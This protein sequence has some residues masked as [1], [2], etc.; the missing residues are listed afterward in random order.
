M[1]KT[2]C[3]WCRSAPRG[4]R[5]RFCSR[6][7]RQRAWR[8]RCRMESFEASSQ[9]GRFA[10]ADPPYPGLSSKYYSDQPSFGGEVDHVALIASLEASG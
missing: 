9:P 1:G 10:Y 6:L 4:A 3:D 2:P 7:C 5:G 8:I